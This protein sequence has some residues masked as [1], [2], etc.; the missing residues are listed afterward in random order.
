MGKYQGNGSL[1]RTTRKRVYNITINFTVLGREIA[2][3]INPSQDRNKWLV[4]MS[5]VR[6][7]RVPKVGTNG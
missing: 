1:T 2:E 7:L 3:W 6:S 5:T 4:V